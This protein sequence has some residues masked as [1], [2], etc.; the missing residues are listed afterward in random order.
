M[1]RRKMTAL[2][3]RYFAKR[4]SRS[5]VKP[6]V[7]YMARR[8]RSYGRARSYV[9]RARGG[10]G[11]GNMKGVIDGVMAGVVGGLAGKYLGSYGQPIGTLG[12]GWFRHNSTLMTMGGI[13][14]GSMLTGMIG[15][16]G[17]GNGNGGFYQ[18]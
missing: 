18:S 13:Q 12:V 2:Q 14:L 4:K 16:G 7:V 1:A 6:K 5:A 15:L 11:N 3:R 9:R 10:G 17:N 8:R